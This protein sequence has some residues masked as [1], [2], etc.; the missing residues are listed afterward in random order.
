MTDHPQL[1]AKIEQ[2]GE[3]LEYHIGQTH[4]HLVEQ[5]EIAAADA[6]ILAMAT[7]NQRHIGLLMDTIV[8]PVSPLTGSRKESEGLSHK[9]DVLYQQASN[10]G[11]RS[12]L[13]RAQA[14]AIYVAGISAVGTVI[15]AIINH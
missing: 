7:T 2:V 1:E 8:G 12:K 15:A 11:F 4:M 3:A 10:G 6:H 14:T 9:V 5:S 13:S